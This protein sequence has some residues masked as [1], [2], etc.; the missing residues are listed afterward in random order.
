[1]G[2]STKDLRSTLAFVADAHDVEAPA[3]LTTELLD[4]LAEL[5]G[6]EY[7]TYQEDD[8]SRRT[9]TAYVWC[10]NEGPLAVPAPHVP[11]SHWTSHDAEKLHLPKGTVDKLSDRISRRERERLREE[12]EYNAEFRIVDRVVVLVEK[13]RTQTALLMF[14][15]QQRDFEERDRKLVVALRPHVAALW[16]KAVARTREVELVS[17]LESRE[18]QDA[19]AIVVC[20]VD[21]RIQ[22]ATAEAKRLLA[23]WFGTRNGHLP[24]ELGEWVWG[25]R[26]EDRYTKRRN[27]SVLTV[28]AAGNFTLTLSERSSGNLR[29]TPR[30]HEVLCLVAEG[31]TNVEIARRLW[32]APST[33]AKH[34]EQAYPK[35]GVRSRTAAVAKLA[36]LADSN[37]P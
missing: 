36:K 28:E 21:G 2:L 3:P 37:Q 6:C 9:V 23:A 11:E 22:H 18:A 32:V 5:V 24:H 30:E 29:L 16:R 8:W 19:R 7:A 14:D 1:M 27:G 17:A 4:Q 15:S 34:L 25:S 35:L 20:G 26:R 31:L 33:V 12:E 10:S 13:T